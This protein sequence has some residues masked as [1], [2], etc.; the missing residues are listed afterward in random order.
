MER[1][2]F[3]IFIQYA[4]VLFFLFCG[5]AYYCFNFVLNTNVKEVVQGKVYRSAQPSGAQLKKIVEKYG[6]RTVINLR[7][8]NQKDF[9]T[10]K[11]TSEQLGVE[12]AGMNLSGNRLASSSELLELIEAIENARTPILLH[13]KSGID[14]SGFASA[15][16][17]IDIGHEDFDNA[18]KQ[19]YV[20]PGPCKRKDFSKNRADYIYDYAH[21]SDI[22]KLYEDFCKQNNLEKNDWKQFVQW[23]KEL[24]PIESLK[25]DYYEPAYSYFP[26]MNNN[27]QFIPFLKLLKDSFVQFFVQILIVILLIYYTK[28]CLKSMK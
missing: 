11:Q 17:A 5:T 13:C 9:E 2:K 28:F 10:E 21:I 4:I 24:P 6:I 14:R 12:F 26:F 19:A 23:A 18:K 25:I 15:L 3:A 8:K 16:A 20:S 27:K 22:L 1:K 7:A